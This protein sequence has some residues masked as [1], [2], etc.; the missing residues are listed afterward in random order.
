[1]TL[2]HQSDNEL[3]VLLETTGPILPVDLIEVCL[4]RPDS[5]TTPFLNILEDSRQDAWE[6]VSDPR[7]FR[8]NHAGKFL[9]AYQEP[10]ALTIFE[11]IYA[12][13]DQRDQDLVEWFGTDLACF[14]ETAVSPLIKVLQRD[15]RPC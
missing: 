7:W 4:E 8:G 14:R 6:L 12:S 2:K 3:L 11:Q 9:L 15:A 13:D 10:L 1:M 5:L